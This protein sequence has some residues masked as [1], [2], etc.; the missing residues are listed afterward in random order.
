MRRLFREP[1]RAAAS[2][3]LDR[4]LIGTERA[5]LGKGLHAGTGIATAFMP[6]VS[7][8]AMT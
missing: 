8:Q 5:M 6:P 1:L 2:Q 4:A 3:E 7:I